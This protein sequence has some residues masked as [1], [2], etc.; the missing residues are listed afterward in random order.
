MFSNITKTLS[1]ISLT[2]AMATGVSAQASTGAAAAAPT[3]ST[4]AAA[5]PAGGVKVGIIDIRRVIAATNEGRRDYEALV[6]KFEPK[7]KEIDGLRNEIESLRKQLQDAKDLTEADRAAR[8]RSIEQKDKNLQRVAEDAQ[9]DF[10]DEQQ[11]I[12]GRIG[13]KLMEVVDKYA[14]Q[15]GYSVIV[16]A[17]ADNPGPVLWASEQSNISQAILEAYNAQSGV[18]APVANAPSAGRP[19]A[20][21]APASTTPSAPKKPATTGTPKQ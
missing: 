21:K 19:G 14:R 13:N 15:N 4:T 17:N 9:K 3:T 16:D 10:Q 12:I 18:A 20:T 8:V 1:L 5:A 2:A 11:Q 7:Q 6:K